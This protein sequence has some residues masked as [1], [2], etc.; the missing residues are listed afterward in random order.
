M[1]SGLSGNGRG[2]KWE[3]GI[4][5]RATKIKDRLDVYTARGR[6]PSAGSRLADRSNYPTTVAMI[7][8]QALVS[9]RT[10]RAGGR[11]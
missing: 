1:G 3:R 7:T 8:R 5:M 2:A 10:Q 9:W 6:H 4:T 11:R